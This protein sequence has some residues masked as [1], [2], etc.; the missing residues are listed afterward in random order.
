MTTDTPAAWR[1]QRFRPG[2]FPHH[3]LRHACGWCRCRRRARAVS[4]GQSLLPWGQV[5]WWGRTSRWKNRWPRHRGRPEG[6]IASPQFHQGGGSPH[7]IHYCHPQGGMTHQRGGVDGRGIGLHCG[8]V[9]GKGGEPIPGADPPTDPAVAADDRC[10]QRSQTD[11]AVAGNNG[12]HPL[13]QLRRH[14][15]M[16]EQ[17]SVVVGVNVDKT[18]GDNASGGINLLLGRELGQ[19]ADGEMRSPVIATSARNRDCPV[20]SITSPWRMIRSG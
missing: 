8:D 20:P 10:H 19:I 18:G 11:A 3:R 16:G 4:P 1:W 7:I 2:T 15:R 5:C 17:Q 12:G 14:R 6:A 13:T 9:V